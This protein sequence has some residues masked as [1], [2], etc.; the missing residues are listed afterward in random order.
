MRRAQL[1]TAAAALLLATAANAAADAP[2]TL[3]SG[4][5]V[6]TGSTVFWGQVGFPGVWLELVHGVDPLTEIG[7]KL[8]LDYGQQG[9]IDGCCHSFEMDFQFLIRRNFFDNGRIW[10]AGTFAPGLSLYFPTGATQVGLDIPVGIQFGFPISPVV[11]VNA[12]FDLAMYAVFPSNFYSG[13]FAV[14]ILFG[15]GLEYLAQRNFVL[16]FQLKLGPTIFTL[17]DSTA[18]FTLYAMVGAAYKF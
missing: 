7:G 18:E 10:I 12:S 3:E 5:T 1:A 11:T 15:V 13:Y 8:G 16:T 17:P 6:G 14:P 4:K 2:L 9:V